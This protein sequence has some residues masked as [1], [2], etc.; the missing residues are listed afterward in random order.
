MSHTR[1]GNIVLEP[2]PRHA[3]TAEEAR[4]A[5]DHLA[6]CVTPA[7]FDATATVTVRCFRNEL[8]T[9]EY[10]RALYDLITREY[11]VPRLR[12]VDPTPDAAAYFFDLSADDPQS[13]DILSGD[14]SGRTRQAKF[15][16]LGEYLGV[17]QG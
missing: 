12:V 7:K 15:E 9:R 16:T 5:M 2:L 14:G 17:K 11:G 6:E 10:A 4:A 3:L 1:N 13:V 8:M